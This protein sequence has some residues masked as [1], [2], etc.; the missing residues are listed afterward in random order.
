MVG[1]E[2]SSTNAVEI[3]SVPGTI[4]YKDVIVPVFHAVDD[5]DTTQQVMAEEIANVFGIQAQFSRGEEWDMQGMSVNDF[6]EVGAF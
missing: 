4:S 5:G 1:V 3:S 6:M 2:L